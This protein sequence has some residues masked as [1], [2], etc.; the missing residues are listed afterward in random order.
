MTPT[1]GLFIHLGLANL[2]IENMFEN[3]ITKVDRRRHGG[4]GPEFV[5]CLG[6]KNVVGDITS[7]NMEDMMV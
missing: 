4:Y 7:C 1:W 5:V 2:S 6:D 3:V